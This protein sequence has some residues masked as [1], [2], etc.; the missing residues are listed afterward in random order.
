MSTEQTATPIQ[1]KGKIVSQRVVTSDTPVEA[2]AKPIAPATM[3]HTP[4]EPVLASRPQVLR[5]STYKIKPPTQNDALYVTINDHIFYEGTVIEQYAPFEIFFN[6]KDTT[7]YQW[8]T[9]LTRLISAIFRR[10]GDVSFLVEELCSI[11]DPAG[12][13]FAPGG[14]L[15]K[16][17]VNEI[18]I[19]V[20]MHMKQLKEENRI[21]QAAA[22][23]GHAMEPSVDK[24]VTSKLQGAYCASCQEFAVVVI[25][26]CETCRNCGAGKC[27]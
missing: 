5:G 3:G 23:T 13:Y 16:S 2:D 4:A 6:T 22:S 19:I 11:Y 26:G 27:G 14:V 24:S 15:I 7:S 1:V 10:G 25:D 21:R 9:A 20:G 17:V 18:G 8:L 12:G